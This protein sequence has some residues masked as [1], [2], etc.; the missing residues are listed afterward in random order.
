MTT[1]SPTPRTTRRCAAGSPRPTQPDSDFPIQNL[2]LGRFRRAGSDEPLRI[3]VAIGDQ[4]LD[5]KLAQQQSPWPDGV[6]E[7]LEPLAAGDLAAFMALGRPAW[8]TLRAALSAALAEGSDTGAVPGTVPAAAGA[9]RRWRCPAASATTPTSTP[10]STTRSRWAQLMRPDNPLLPNYKW[11]PI[12]YHGRASSITLGG[13][14]EAA[15]GQTRSSGDMPHFGPSQRLDYELEL[16]LWVGVGNELGQPVAMDAGRGPAVRRDAAQRLVGARHPGL[17]IPAARARSWPR[18][19]RPWSRRGS[20]PSTRWRR[21]GGRSRGPAGDPQPLPY[22]DSAFNRAAG[23]LDITLEVWLQTA[24]MREQGLP[25]LRLSQSNAA[26]RLLDAG[27]T[28]GA[29]HQQRLQPADRRPAGHRHAVG[30]AAR[31]GRFAA[32]AVGWAAASR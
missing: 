23:A 8:Q 3:G 1:R 15:A 9:G 4:V 24:R 14:R 26:R 27:A 32:G 18:I 17:G 5:L 19:S 2:P 13:P 30:P 31:A 6:S 12:G 20:S 25:A 7:L 21:S 29:P 11:V 22:L 10:A 28:G 16:G